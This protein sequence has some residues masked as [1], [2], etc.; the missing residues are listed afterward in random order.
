MRYGLGLTYNHS[1]KWTFRAG[2]AYDETPVSN[3]Y[4][5]ARIPAMIVNGWP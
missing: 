5:T 4:R 1:E 2:I 3:Q